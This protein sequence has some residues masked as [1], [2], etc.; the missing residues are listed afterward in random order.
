MR[1]WSYSLANAQIALGDVN[2]AEVSNREA[3]AIEKSMNAEQNQPATD[4][5]IPVNE[6][7]IEVMRGHPEHAEQLYRDMLSRPSDDPVPLLNAHSDLAQLLAKKGNPSEADREYRQT[8]AQISNLQADLS[9]DDFRLSYLSSL[10]D[11]CDNYVEFLVQ[12]KEIDRALEVTESI[13]ARVLNERA[14]QSGPT[15]AVSVAAL[16]QAA[17]SSGSIFLAYW[18]TQHKSY[19]WVVRP[20]GVE[21]KELT[22]GQSRIA[23]LVNRYRSLLENLTRSSDF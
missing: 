2:G 18:L 3:A 4:L 11:F 22:A 16:K 20:G 10:I 8:L 17:G 23:A 14:A 12:R 15:P 19:L 9:D 13:R 1:H 21:L 5:F 7:R 6:A